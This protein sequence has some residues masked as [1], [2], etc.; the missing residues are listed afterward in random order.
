MD[1]V[2]PGAAVGRRVAARSSVLLRVWVL[3][4]NV[5]D[6]EDVS[7]FE[8]VMLDAVDVG[9]FAADD[10]VVPVPNLLLGHLTRLV[11]LDRHGEAHDFCS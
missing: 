4:V 6:R 10:E 5:L 8:G 11:V 1:A 9:R 7:A 3:R 2:E